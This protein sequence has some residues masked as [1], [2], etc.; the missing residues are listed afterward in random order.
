LV[1][2]IILYYDARSKKQQ[3]NVEGNIEGRKE[4]TGRRGRKRKQLID[5]F[6]KRDGSGN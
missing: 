1:N 4:M 5:D 6:R 3:K 2:E